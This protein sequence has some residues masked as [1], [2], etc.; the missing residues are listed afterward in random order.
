MKLELRRNAK[1]RKPGD[2]NGKVPVSAAEM[3]EVQDT[4]VRFN[5]KEHMGSQMIWDARYKAER[6]K[7]KEKQRLLTEKGRVGFEA[8]AWGLEYAAESLLTVMG[9]SK[10]Q[11]DTRATAWQSE[12]GAVADGPPGNLPGPGVSDCTQSSPF[13]GSGPGGLC[14]AGP[15]VGVFPLLRRGDQE[16]VS[17]QVL[18]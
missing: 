5:Q 6:D 3:Y 8:T 2:S 17:H 10:N 1:S 16:G 11:S 13:A 9:F 7:L 14:R 12:L 4:Y 15:P 18:R